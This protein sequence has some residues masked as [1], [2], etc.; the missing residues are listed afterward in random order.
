M[1]FLVFIGVLIVSLSACSKYQKVLKSTDLDY[2]YK[3][4]NSYYDEGKYLKAL[5][6]Y[7]ELIAIYRGTSKAEDIYYRYAFCEYYLGDLILANYRFE[8]FSRTYPNS[9]YL[10]ECDYMAAYCSY[11]TSPR[12]SLD[13]TSTYE[14]IDEL[15]LFI[16]RYPESPRVDSC[17]A[18]L[19]DLRIKLEK[20]SF[21]NSKLYFKT[22]YYQ[23]AIVAFNNTL[24][25]FPDTDYKEEI[26]YYL[27]RA[28]YKLAANS[29]E[30]KKQERFENTIKAY[31]K[32]A[33]SFPESPNMKKAE[34]LYEVAQMELKKI[35]EN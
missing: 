18:L 24:N 14:A 12:Y 17:S 35:K 27:L 25:D 7:E 23:S 32:F 16:Q 21:E 3:M 11:L 10:E 8:N 26:L 28:H 31:I 33:D 6:I 20:K 34:D 1:R 30:L 19:D 29:V 13:Q 4:A 15:N 5:P 2:K 9:K 22:Q